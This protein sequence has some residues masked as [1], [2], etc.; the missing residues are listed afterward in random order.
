MQVVRVDLVTGRVRLAC[1]RGLLE[2]KTYSAG[3][4]PVLGVV[5]AGGAAGTFD[6]PSRGLYD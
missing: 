2:L 6:S 5:V 4:H 3:R 1:V